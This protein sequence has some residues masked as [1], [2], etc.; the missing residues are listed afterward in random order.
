MRKNSPRKYRRETISRLAAHT[1]SMTEMFEEY[2]LLKKGEGLARRTID[3]Y[4]I[5]YQHLMNYFGRELSAE[6]MTT[7]LFASWITYM[8]EEM[9]YSPATINIRVRTNRSF[10]RYAY[11][12]KGWIQDPIHK[13]FKPI[14]API[15]NVEA[16]TAEE[17]RRLIGA[18][19][20]ET[21]VGY[22]TKVITFV[23][24][25]TMLRVSELVD[26]KRENVDLKT[27]SVRLEAEDTKTRVG[28]IVPISPRTAKMIAEYMDET[29]DFESEYLFLTYEGNRIS[30]STVRDDL[31]VVGQVA[32]ITNKCVS[33]HTI[34]HT[35][36]LFYILNG[37]DPFS[38]QRIL[39]HSHMN[40]VR[41]YVQMTN[42]D[43]QNQHSYHSPLNYV[44]KK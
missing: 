13:R 43:V 2:M 32:K 10:L 41:R 16:F 17:F 27:M 24:L 5:N 36:A 20:D 1:M 25:D 26:I 22:R 23:L 44:F 31:R 9:E 6:E 12:E 42:M 39:G 11:E 37:G 30:E 19:N 40:M 34:R 38:L 4:Y 8:I 21:Y 29:A 3:E 7:E 33:P 35:G 14:K 18:I 15:D 28:R